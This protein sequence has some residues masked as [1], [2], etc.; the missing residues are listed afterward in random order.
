MKTSS[1]RDLEKRPRST[2]TKWA[3]H[4]RTLR[5]LHR[6]LAREHEEH[7]HASAVPTDKDT[8]DFA[9][10]ASDVRERDDLFAALLSEGS[11]MLEI[12]AALLRIE[13]GTYGICEATG[14]T[15]P[16]ERLQALP[17]TRYTREAAEANERVYRRNK[18]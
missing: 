14:R 11:R 9:D 1:D 18:P 12:E 7:F 16:D 8:H 17:W 3:W 5:A 4:H 13:S 10:S 6:R 2:P 15:I